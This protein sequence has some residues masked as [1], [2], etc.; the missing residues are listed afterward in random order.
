M[1]VLLLGNIFDKETGWYIIHSLKDAGHDVAAVDVRAIIYDQGIEKGQKIIMEEIEDVDI[2]PDI[3]MAMKGLEMTPDTLRAIKNRFPKAK[4]VNWFFDKYL[5]K[6]PIWENKILFDHVRL[7]DY[8]FCSLKG[9]S[10]R[11]TADGFKNFHYLDEAC[12]P[13]LNGETILTYYEEKKYGSDIAFCGTIGINRI[14]KERIPTLVKVAQAGFNMK[15]WGD[16]V[17]DI[18][19][20]PMQIRKLCTQVRVS[21][22]EHSSVVQSSLINLG[23]D[24]DNELDMGYSARVYRVMCAGGLYFSKYTKGIETMFKINKQ[25]EKLTDD[26]EMVVYY[27]DEDMIELLDY[28]LEHN[29]MREQ[30]ADNGRVTVL[31]KH[32]FKDRIRKMIKIIGGQK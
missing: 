31:E 18:K 17:G 9:V 30:I 1:K 6:L 20:V 23:I 4:L 14:H 12:F 22:L 26:L 10:D 3:I 5:G 16:I 21:N 7:F 32:T 8:Y 28:L 24:Q 13:E 11:M 25:G 19:Y 27:N 2:N 29:E 15:I